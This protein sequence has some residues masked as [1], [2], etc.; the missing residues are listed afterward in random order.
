MK[1]ETLLVQIKM[2]EAAV[3]GAL[4]G[5]AT[6]VVPNLLDVAARNGANSM[7][8][9]AIYANPKLYTYVQRSY[10]PLTNEGSGVESFTVNVQRGE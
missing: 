3:P 9:E 2:I 10:G 7:K 1:G 8:I 6:S 4:A 5:K